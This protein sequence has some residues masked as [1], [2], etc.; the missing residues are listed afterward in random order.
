MSDSL[1]KTLKWLEDNGNEHS[2]QAN[3]IR[4]VLAERQSYKSVYGTVRE[5]RDAKQILDTV[6]GAQKIAELQA[7]GA[8][9][10]EV[11]AMLNAGDPRVLEAI[12]ETPEAT[13]GIAKIFPNLLDKLATSNPQEVSEALSPYILGFMDN[14][15]L[16]GAIDSMVGAFNAGKPDDA[17]KILA[18]I[19]A[20]SQKQI[21]G[22]RVKVASIPNV[23]PLKS[24]SR[25]LSRTVTLERLRTLLMR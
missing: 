13:K 18:S 8:R 12:L 11:D 1:R 6:G 7:V 22:K 3:E 14:Q 5:A 10:A 15:G 21:W 25:I 16:F 19:V 17:K 4:K 23:L 24:R 9:M 2:S 20:W